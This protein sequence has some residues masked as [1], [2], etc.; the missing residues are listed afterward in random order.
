MDEFAAALDKEWLQIPVLNL[1]GLTGQY[2]FY[3]RFDAR[4]ETPATDEHL[5]PP[6]EPSMRDQLGLVLRHT[7]GPQDVIVI[8]SFDREATP[9]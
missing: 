7:K 3:L 5:D 1:T 6:L 4:S 8:D 9:N 2:D